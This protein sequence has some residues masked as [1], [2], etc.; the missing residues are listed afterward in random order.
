MQDSYDPDCVFCNMALDKT[1][2]FFYEVRILECSI[3]FKLHN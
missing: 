3:E 2:E 1:T